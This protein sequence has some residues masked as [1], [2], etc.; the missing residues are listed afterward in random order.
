MIGKEI[1]NYTII[2]RLGAGG[3]GT[4]Y[5]AVNKYIKQKKVAI[6]VIH[7]EMA[8]DYTKKMLM[9]EAEH[10]ASLDHA[11]IVKFLNYHIDDDGTIYLIMEYAEGV[12]L[13]KFINEVNGLVVEDRV[14]NIFEP[15]LDGFGYAHKK[16]ILH[17]DIK[18]S[19]IIITPEGTPKILDFGIAKI[20]G[21]ESE[22]D[23][24]IVGTPSYM[25]PEQ[26]RGEEL[27]NRSDIYSLGVLLHQ[28]MTGNAPYDT[29]T[30]SEHEINDKVVNEK[31]PPMRSFY[32]YVGEK[33]QKVVDKATAKSPD[34]RY[35]DCQDFK[36]DLHKAIYPP[37]IPRWIIG[38]VAAV[39]LVCCGCGIWFWDYTRTKVSYYKDYTEQWGVP[40]GIGKLSSSEYSHKYSAY[41]IESSRGKV[42]RLTHVNSYGKPVD[43]TESEHVERPVDAYYYY[44]PEGQ[45]ARVKV[46][47]RNG[48]VQYVKVYND[49][50][51][52]VVFQYDDEHGTEKTLGT[53][54]VGYVNAFSNGL[55]ESKGKISRYHLTYD[56]KGYVTR[57]DYAGLF[58]A[59]VHDNDNLYGRTYVR[60]DKGRVIEESYLNASGGPQATKWGL[61]IKTFKYDDDDN[62]VKSEYL[63]VDRLP[64]LDASD[65]TAVYEMAYDKYGNIIE[66]TYRAD[67][68]SLM[69]PQRSQVAGVRLTY[70]DRGNIT[71]EEY[72]GIDG[73]TTYNMEGV[74]VNVYTWDENGYK[75]G[76]S[77]YDADGSKITDKDKIWRMA[78]ENDDRGNQLSVSYFNENDEPMMY[79]EDYA[80]IEFTYDSLGNTTSL[81]TYGLDGNLTRSSQ[82]GGTAGFRVAHDQFGNPTK[83]VYYNEASEPAPTDDNITV[84]VR[85]YD[86]RGN[87][88]RISYFEDEDCTIPQA[89]NGGVAVYEYVYDDNGN[90]IRD[91]N[92]NTEGKLTFNANH[93]AIAKREYDDAGNKISVRYYAPDET[94]V[95]NTDKVAGTLWSYDDHGNVT[96]EINIGTDGK[97]VANRLIVR[98]EYDKNDNIISESVFNIDGTPAKGNLGFHRSEKDYDSNKRNTETRYL[99][100]KG[101]PVGYNGTKVAVIRNEYDKRGNLVMTSYFGTDKKPVNNGD[102][103]ASQRSEY[104]NLGRITRQLYFDVNGNPTDPSVMVPEGR[105]GYDTYGNI[106]YLAS[107]DGKGNLIDNPQ[108][109][110]S[111]IRMT[112]DVKG[113]QTECSYYDIE[114][115]PVVSKKWG[116]HKAKSEYDKRGN[117]TEMA[118]FNAEDAPMINTSLGFHRKVTAYD[119]LNRMVSETIYD[120]AGKE[121]AFPGA[122]FSRA[123]YTYNDDT[124]TAS[125]VKLYSPSGALVS[126]MRWVNG[127]WVVDSGNSG[128]SAAAP[129]SGGDSSDWRAELR[130]LQGQLPMNLGS[131]AGNLEFTSID[132]KGAN[133]VEFTFTAEE[134]KYEMNKSLQKNYEDFIV[135]FANTIKSG[136]PASVRI[137]V[138]LLDKPGREVIKKT[139]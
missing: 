101:N 67:D 86:R 33:T 75:N 56:D 5:L 63:T 31:L 47:D 118:F 36:K 21:D 106:N 8:N 77:Y 11:N 119:D 18:P 12:S 41:R 113:N 88:T 66:A 136:F 42:R 87:V 70:D 116:Y 131:D 57:I 4:V 72:I 137:T 49:N 76:I 27:D 17:R 132:I 102:N 68:G 29:T 50:L 44:T 52:T 103:Y 130:E 123:E 16:G 35:R 46:L 127:N 19:N 30:L 115:K 32:K 122:G 98:F 109:G 20:I 100:T 108:I 138:R 128:Q 85:E 1:L 74:A 39:V 51:K 104:D 129:S 92:Y 22:T 9:Q 121:C 13:E 97:P 54:T 111:I 15:I 120:A 14:C 58:N 93:W 53:Q 45:V 55:N 60:D 126:S 25:S 91:N 65:G 34:D 80:R 7:P 110:A 84:I 95:I 37:K 114:D 62:W 82:V 112:Y 38:T 94:P 61:G 135:T 24:V 3:M 81:F 107:C 48:R 6:K 96:E 139:V 124:A 59:L 26:V 73:E 105:T 90:Q 134:S 64:S 10:L 99:D 71:R 43:D 69:L 125:R 40:V 28:M 83:I 2:E 89:D 133:A 78:V 23:K 79:A 117:Q